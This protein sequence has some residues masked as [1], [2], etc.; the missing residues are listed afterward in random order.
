[1]LDVGDY[2]PKS[3]SVP[4]NPVPFGQTC[5]V[6]TGVTCN[7]AA[8]SAAVPVNNTALGVGVKPAAAVG[9]VAAMSTF[10]QSTA[11]TESD[12]SNYYGTYHTALHSTATVPH[13]LQCRNPSDE[14][15]VMCY[16]QGSYYCPYC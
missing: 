10:L 1:V 6:G 13:S 5:T 12:Q 4:R 16:D 9:N 14:C 11:N 2:N 15:V 8:L 3:T 7:V